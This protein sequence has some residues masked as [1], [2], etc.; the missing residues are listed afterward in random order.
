MELKPRNSNILM[1]TLPFVV[2]KPLEIGNQA[3]R[4]FK[5]H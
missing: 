4:K 1:T 2:T 5:K 3:I